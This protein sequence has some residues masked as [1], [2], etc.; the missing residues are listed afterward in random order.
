MSNTFMRDNLFCIDLQEKPQTLTKMAKDR[1]LFNSILST[2]STK[3]MK[4]TEVLNAWHKCGG[5]MRDLIW[6]CVV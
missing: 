3:Q 2:V 5:I 6:L 1:K 4:S